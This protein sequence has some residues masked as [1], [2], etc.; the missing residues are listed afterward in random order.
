[1][2]IPNVEKEVLVLRAETKIIIYNSS[3]MRRKGNKIYPSTL[4]HIAY[5]ARKK[6]RGYFSWTIKKIFKTKIN[7]DVSI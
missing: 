6:R 2:G 4:K 7:P 5:T 3:I 1:M